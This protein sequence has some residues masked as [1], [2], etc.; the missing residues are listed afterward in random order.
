MSN[1]LRNSLLIIVAVIVCV[2]TPLLGSKVFAQSELLF[3]V[4]QRVSYSAPNLDVV[5]TDYSQDTVSVARSTPTMDVQPMVV[6]TTQPYIEQD[7]EE[8]TFL[9]QSELHFPAQRSVSYSAPD[10]TVVFAGHSHTNESVAK[11]VVMFSHNVAINTNTDSSVEEVSAEDTFIVRS[12]LHFPARQRVSHSA[13]SLETVFAD[14]P[15]YNTP[16]EKALAP[17]HKYSATND[18]DTVSYIEEVPANDKFLAQSEL[19]FPAR[20]RV[21]YFAPSLDDVFVGYVYDAVPINTISTNKKKGNLREQRKIARK[22]ATL[23]EEVAVL[24]RRLAKLKEKTANDFGCGDCGPMVQNL[25]KFLNRN[26]FTLATTG[27][28]SVGQETSFFGPRTLAALKRFQSAYYIPVTGVVNA[29]TRKIINSIEY[30]VLGEITATDCVTSKETVV[31]DV[32]S[33]KKSDGKIIRNDLRDKESD[34][35]TSGNFFTDFFKKIANFFRTL[36]QWS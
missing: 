28:G 25:Q 7:P 23:K 14:Y 26:G 10:M 22:I 6:V 8:D 4:T 24:Q 9:V 27:P 13:P 29:R 12:E 35:S 18:T 21:S 30:N 1:A 31:T 20:Q 36:F 32:D 33:T 17:V 16:V 19:R 34:K 2:A 3:P 11:E 15:Q 5:F